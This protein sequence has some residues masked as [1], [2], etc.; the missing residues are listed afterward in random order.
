MEKKNQHIYTVRWI[1]GGKLLCSTGSPAAGDDME[2]W[3]EGGEGGWDG[4]GYR[5]NHGCSVWC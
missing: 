5:D 2:E 1:A 4:R 3:G